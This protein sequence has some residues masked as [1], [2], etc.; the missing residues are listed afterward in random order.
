MR[1]ISK[2]RRQVNADADEIRSA[3][4]F[5]FP[6]CQWCHRA[7]T[8][9]HEISRGAGR[10]VSL[11]VRAALLHLCNECHRIMDWLPVS[12]QLAIKKLADPEGYDRVA[13]NRLRGRTDNAITDAEVGLWVLRLQMVGGRTY[14]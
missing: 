7:A 6:W 4:R 3:Y 2:K 13:V 14:V 10:G 11:A 1:R 9:L 5:E 12:G 8:D